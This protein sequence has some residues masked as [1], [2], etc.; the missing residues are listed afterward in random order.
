MERTV[1]L[2]GRLLR[3]VAIW[4]DVVGGLGAEE[5]VVAVAVYHA[6]LLADHRT[7]LR[8]QLQILSAQGAYAVLFLDFPLVV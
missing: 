1:S 8:R 6:G 3:L 2:L 7:E 4:H 5:R